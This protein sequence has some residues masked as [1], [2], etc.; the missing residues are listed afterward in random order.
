VGGVP[1]L[2][3]GV[4]EIKRIHETA[5]KNMEKFSDISCDFVDRSWFFARSECEIRNYIPS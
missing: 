5:R 3:D 2:K 1:N 4:L